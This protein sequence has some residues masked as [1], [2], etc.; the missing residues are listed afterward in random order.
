MLSSQCISPVKDSE[1][2]REYI[3]V[4]KVNIG[5]DIPEKY[6]D[7]IVKA[8]DPHVELVDRLS[9]SLQSTKV[10]SILDPHIN[11]LTS[12]FFKA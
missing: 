8:D 11:R 7:I 10:H 5:Y 4:E 12:P 1:L 3:G 2:A 6:R 9:L